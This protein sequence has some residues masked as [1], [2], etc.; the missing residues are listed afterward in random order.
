MSEER[1]INVTDMDKIAKLN[2]YRR[3]RK[4]ES[5]LIKT[6]INE[7]V[8]DCLRNGKG[9]SNIVQCNALLKTVNGKEKLIEDLKG[10]LQ[11]LLISDT[12]LSSELTESY[13]IM[14]AVRR[15]EFKLKKF[16]ETKSDEETTRTESSSRTGVKL[17]KF[18][19]KRFS[20]NSLEWETF[21]ET[22]ETAIEHNK[23]LKK[24]EKFTYLRGYLEGTALQAI[25]GF[26]LTNDNYSNARNLLK[27][28]YGNPQLI[29]SCHINNLIELEAVSG[30]NVKDLRDLFDKIKI[31]VRALKTTGIH[32]DQVRL[33]LIPAV[34]KKL[35]NVIRLQIS[36]RLGKKTRI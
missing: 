14:S 6:P 1:E 20:G 7:Q 30:S 32:E 36:R 26:P 12:D 17:R 4:A 34:L 8:E 2:S 18:E 10:K 13:K 22:F 15:L 9:F 27:E 25:D 3:L 23:N 31:S 28:R 29:T 35:P 5:V 24:I 16:M 19:I 21:K 33:L 11:S